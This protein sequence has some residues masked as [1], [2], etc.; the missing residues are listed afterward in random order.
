MSVYVC[1]AIMV[2]KIRPWPKTIILQIKSSQTLASPTV[3]TKHQA[4]E[5]R[6]GPCLAGASLSVCRYRGMY[7]WEDG[8]IGHYLR[9]NMYSRPPTTTGMD[10]IGVLA[11]VPAGL[12]TPFFGKRFLC[13]KEEMSKAE[14][15]QNGFSEKHQV[16]L[17]IHAHSSLRSSYVVCSSGH[18]THKFLACDLHSGC[19][20]HGSPGLRKRL[21]LSLNPLCNSILAT[22]FTCRNGVEQVPYSVVCDHSQ[23][24]LD[25]S[26]EDFC[27]HPSCSGSEQF[28]CVNKQVSNKW[29]NLENRWCSADICCKWY[30]YVWL[31]DFARWL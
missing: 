23:D 22:L 25:S 14:R 21:D 24:C 30:T 20:Q 13:E 12:K 9:Y 11:I 6:L 5:K 28:E 27:D 26:D 19:R 18:F 17:P 15:N 4:C 8:T 16:Q 3:R 2:R 10:R 29:D 1:G 31:A 7:Q